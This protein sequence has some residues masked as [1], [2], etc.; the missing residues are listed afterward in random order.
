MECHDIALYVV[1][2]AVDTGAYSPLPVSCIHI[3][4]LFYA[5]LSRCVLRV[6]RQSGNE[7][8]KHVGDIRIL[9]HKAL[10]A[11]IERG[12]RKN[13]ERDSHILS[14]FTGGSLPSLPFQL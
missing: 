5:V 11:A 4:E 8:L 12:C 1:T 9:L 10:Y 2:E 3:R 14:A 7:I 13:S 6:G